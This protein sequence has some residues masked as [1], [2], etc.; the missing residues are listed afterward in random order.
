M[1]SFRDF[2]GRI[3]QRV[4]V[5]FVGDFRLVK[6]VLQS[7]CDR[8]KR[9]S[10]HFARLA[11]TDAQYTCLQ[12]YDSLCK[13]LVSTTTFSATELVHRSYLQ[14]CKITKGLIPSDAN[15]PRSPVKPDP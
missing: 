7:F 13:T 8:H 5:N 6:H 9:V 3:R 14:P 11:N 4:I 2:L 15:E 12:V 1:L 10:F